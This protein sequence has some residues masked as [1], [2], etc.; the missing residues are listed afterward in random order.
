MKV[1][2]TQKE[3]NL[4]YF[5]MKRMIK[6]QLQIDLLKEMSDIDRS[7]FETELNIVD[8]FSKL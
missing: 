3:I 5:G 8:K 2:L 7:E 1:E 6:D 4:I